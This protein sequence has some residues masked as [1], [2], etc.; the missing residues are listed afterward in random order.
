MGTGVSWL[1]SMILNGS[2]SNW[3]RMVLLSVMT[4]AMMPR[5]RGYREQ[6]IG[7][8]SSEW[9]EPRN[10]STNSPLSN[11]ANLATEFPMSIIKFTILFFLRAK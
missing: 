6:S 2:L 5:S 7:R 10:T 1:S 8:Q 11:I 9:L 4:E 3:R